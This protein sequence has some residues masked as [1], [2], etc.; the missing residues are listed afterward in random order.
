MKVPMGVH[1]E[2]SHFEEGDRV[3]VVDIYYTYRD[4]K[5]IGATGK[6]L[7]LDFDRSSG[8]H[9][10]VFLDDP[11]MQKWAATEWKP[12]KPGEVHYREQWFDEAELKKLRKKKPKKKKTKKGKKR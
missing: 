11:E 12:P 8:W 3:E 10:C 2:D 5:I 1:T 7:R 9:Y 4:S 6:I